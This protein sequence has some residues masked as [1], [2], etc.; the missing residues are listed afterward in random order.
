MITK[1]VTIKVLPN[2]LS[3]TLVIWN[4]ICIIVIIIY[5]VNIDKARIIWKV[6]FPKSLGPSAKAMIKSNIAQSPT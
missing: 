3:F 2:G 4:N 6:I 5:T 1:I